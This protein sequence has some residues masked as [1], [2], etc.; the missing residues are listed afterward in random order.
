MFVL[1]QV[2]W[3]QKPKSLFHKSKDGTFSRYPI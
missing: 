2:R 1:L 3:I